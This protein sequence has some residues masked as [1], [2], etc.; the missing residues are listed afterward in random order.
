MPRWLRVCLVVCL[1]VPLQAQPADFDE[2]VKKARFIFIG[3]VVRLGSS[4]MPTIPPTAQTAVVRVRKVLTGEELLGGF[5][6]RE[7]TVVM[8]QPSRLERAAFFTNVTVYGESLAVEE[9]APGRAGASET[10]AS[11]I[12]A[13]RRRN[14]DRELEARK[15]SAALIVSGRVVEVRVPTGRPRSEHDPMW[16]VAVVQVERVLKGEA[17]ALVEVVFPTSND[18]M[19]RRAPKF[20]PGDAGVWILHRHEQGWTALDPRDFQRGAK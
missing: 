17:G 13:A 15:S 10:L 18:E 16:G 1:A 4:T 19:W 14:A 3:D 12:A 11:E 6:G 9:V 2:L 5:E 7:I 20:T 8:L